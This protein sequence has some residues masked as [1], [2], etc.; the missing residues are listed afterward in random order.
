MPTSTADTSCTFEIRYLGDRPFTIDEDK[1]RALL[2]RED[3]PPAIDFTDDIEAGN[4]VMVL[5][6]RAL[7][8]G[9]IT[10][11]PGIALELHGADD[12]AGSGVYLLL[13]RARDPHGL[14][15]TSGWIDVKNLVADA[16]QR[17][18]ASEDE[19]IRRTIEAVLG[20]ANAILASCSLPVQAAV[21]GLKSEALD[22][23]IHDLFSRRASEV[24]NGG[25]AVQLAALA[26]AMDHRAAASLLAD[27]AD[28]ES[29]EAR[30]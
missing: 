12:D 7:A 18:G 21:L 24:N 6:D 9:A 19:H 22:E 30:T 15:L 29:A 3:R 28:G 8:D 5:F 1:L 20:E 25:V 2:S 14:R 10:V 11:P 13:A 17:A 4:S 27:I 23:T 16:E 26:E